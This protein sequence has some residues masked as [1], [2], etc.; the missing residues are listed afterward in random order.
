MR[1]GH[2]EFIQLLRRMAGR[3]ESFRVKHWDETYSCVILVAEAV[4]ELQEKYKVSRRTGYYWISHW[5]RDDGFWVQRTRL[6]VVYRDGKAVLR[7][8]FKGRSLDLII[9]EPA[10]P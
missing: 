7:G 8:H 3:E 6:R 4:K 2:E 10:P 9:K 1:P 5:L